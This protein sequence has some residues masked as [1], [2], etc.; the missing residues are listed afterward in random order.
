[1]EQVIEKKVESFMNEVVT[2]TRSLLPEDKL[3]FEW[4]EYDS[5]IYAT[6][7]IDVD[8]FEDNE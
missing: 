8:A 1:M 4:E 3:V 6:I 5:M 2:L 7:K